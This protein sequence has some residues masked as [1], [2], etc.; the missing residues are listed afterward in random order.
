MKI[1][2]QTIVS[3][4]TVKRLALYLYLLE[5]LAGQAV[6]YV[7]C[8]E[9][10]KAFGFEPTQVRKDFEVTGEVGTPRIGFRV[11]TLFAR[12]REFLGWDIA[13]DAFLVGAGNLGRA[14]LGYRDFE[15]YGLNIVAAFDR[16][17]RKI[18]SMIFDKEVYPLTRLPELARKMQVNIGIVTVPGAHAQGVVDLMVSSGIK[19]IWNFTPAPV[20]IPKGILLENARLTQS[21]AVL[22]H[23]WARILKESGRE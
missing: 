22:T 10:A 6:E 15:K 18:G 23:N 17:P 19:A 5:N 2:D 1:N 3:R 8:A 21:L 11:V 20:H 4:A 12:I 9:I 14:L 13:R 16:D 7:S